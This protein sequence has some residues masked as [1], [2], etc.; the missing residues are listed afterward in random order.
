MGRFNCTFGYSLVNGSRQLAGI[1]FKK[2]TMQ[3]KCL[4][5][6][7]P[8]QLIYVHGHYQCAVCKTN[9]LPC[10]DG[11]NCNNFFIAEKENTDEG[12]DS[13]SNTNDSH[14]SGQR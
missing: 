12:D 9:A 5:C 13:L 1:A 3:T 11:D 14:Y 8:V 6:G 10:C 4:F 7:N 2:V